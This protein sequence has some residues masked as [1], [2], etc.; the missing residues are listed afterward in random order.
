MDN[1]KKDEGREGKIDNWKKR[2]YK[3]WKKDF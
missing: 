3:K 1:N 2:N